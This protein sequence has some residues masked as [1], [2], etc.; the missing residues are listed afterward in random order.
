MIYDNHLLPPAMVSRYDKTWGATET[1][2]RVSPDFSIR[3]FHFY[4]VEEF[5]DDL[6]VQQ[7]RVL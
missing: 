3:G 4:A 5:A 1:R 6:W 7:E 2:A